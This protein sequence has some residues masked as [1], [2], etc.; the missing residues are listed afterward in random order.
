[1]RISELIT[2]ARVACGVEAGSK[3]RV[4]ELL[5]ELAVADVPDLTAAEAFDSLIERERLGGTGLGHG[6]ALPHGRLK[7]GR[8]AIGALMTLKEGIDFDA[9]DRQPVDLLFALLV[10]EHYTDEHLQILAQLA[11]LFSDARLC[12]TLRGCATGAELPA[13]V[14]DWE[15]RQAAS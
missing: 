6:V 9:P 2:P 13:A 4:L 15:R 11:K 7:S 10:P 8:R 5:G 1:M 3:K 14:A 12:E